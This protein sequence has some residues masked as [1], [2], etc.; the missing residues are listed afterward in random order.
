MLFP[1][2]VAFVAV[3]LGAGFALGP[4]SDQR[5]VLVIRV[6]AI[7]ASAWVIATHLMP[8]AIHEL[9]WPLALVFAAGGVAL[10]S[11]VESI[12]RRIWQHGHAPRSPEDSDAVH[13][14]GVE[15]AFVGLVVHRFGDGLSMGA[16]TASSADASG[17]A[18]VLLAIAAHIVPVTTLMILAVVALRGQK[19]AVVHAGILSLATMAGVVVAGAAVRGGRTDVAPWISAA[20]AGLLVHVVAH[21]LPHG[22]GGKGGGGHAHGH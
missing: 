4:R 7:A 8:E 11:L 3:W 15:I 19:S 20:V 17:R 22:R 5:V 16:Y 21:D 1:L 6:V 10:P 2:I 18:L 12:T 14:A 13:A 9:G